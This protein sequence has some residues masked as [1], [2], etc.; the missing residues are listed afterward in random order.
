MKCKCLRKLEKRGHLILVVK[1]WINEGMRARGEKPFSSGRDGNSEYGVFLQ[2]LETNTVPSPTNVENSWSMAL[3]VSSLSQGILLPAVP[4][5]LRET[6][7]QE[8]FG[9]TWKAGPLVLF[10][11]PHSTAGIYCM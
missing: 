4:E 6:P 8:R 11:S 7:L 5:P 10:S 2:Q 1:G 3:S 9:M